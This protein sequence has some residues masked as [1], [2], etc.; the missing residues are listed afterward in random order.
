MG[1]DLPYFRLWVGDYLSDTAHLSA[2]EHGALLLLT[3]A[4]WPSAGVL[5]VDP[6][7][8]ARIARIESA[9]WEMVWEAIAEFF[10]AVDGGKLLHRRVAAEHAVVLAAREKARER[11]RSASLARWR[12]RADSAQDAN[13]LPK[14]TAGNAQVLHSQSLSSPA[15]M[16][17]LFPSSPSSSS[18]KTRSK[19]QKRKRDAP[20]SPELHRFIEQF[21]HAFED[22]MHAKPTSQRGMESILVLPRA[23]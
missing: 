12:K 16:P 17:E 18:S 10:D 8:L 14:Q 9:K 5:P 11:G 15:A 4:A 7:R 3:L 22:A 2:E 19:A 21:S 1:H 20:A 23:F 13:A 6:S